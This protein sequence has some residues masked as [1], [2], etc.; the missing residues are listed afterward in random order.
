[1]SCVCVSPIFDWI[2]EKLFQ[3]NPHLLRLISAVYQFMMHNSM[4]AQA[5]LHF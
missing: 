3:F 2:F 5:A 1:M 4:Q